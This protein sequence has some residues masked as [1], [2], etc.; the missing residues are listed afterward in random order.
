MSL[1][2]PQLHEFSVVCFLLVNSNGTNLGF[3]PMLL[4][5]GAIGSRI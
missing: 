3:D 4:N 1:N 2:I 5:R